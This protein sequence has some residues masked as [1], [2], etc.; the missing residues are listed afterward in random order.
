MNIDGNNLKNDITNDNYISNN[1]SLKIINCGNN[2]DSKYW[3]KNYN[4]GY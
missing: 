4:G 1:S 2:D 3:F